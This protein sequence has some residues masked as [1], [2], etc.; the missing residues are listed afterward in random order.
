M[1]RPPLPATGALKKPRHR[2]DLVVRHVHGRPFDA[3]M[4]ALELRACVDAERGIEVGERLVHQE[5]RGLPRD[6]AAD[7]DTLTLAARQL[8]RLPLEELLET[9]HV[10]DLA[11][12]PID[13]GLRHAS[14]LQSEG[15]VVVDGHVRVERVVLEDHRDVA[16]LGRDVVD[17]AL[18]DE[19]VAAR[20]LFEPGDHAKGGRLAA[21]GGSD[22]HE[23]LFVL[24]LQG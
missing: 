23:E 10:R 12:A 9:E 22:E 6:R 18:A 19:D 7:R 14:Q 21:T 1:D 8:L 17:E 11:H 4:Q 5:H 15:D 2:L 13:L 16:I 20:L 24:D 3:L